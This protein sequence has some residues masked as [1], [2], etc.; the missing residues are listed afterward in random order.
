MASELLYFNGVNATRGEYAHE[1]MTADQLADLI[2][3]KN[4]DTSRIDPEQAQ[5]NELRWRDQLRRQGAFAV[6][7]GVQP[8][9]LAETGW[10]V[11]FPAGNQAA[12]REA[13]SELLEWR[14]AQAG[15]RYR[16]CIG[17]G[18]YR[19]GEGKADFLRRQGAAPSGPV[20]PDRF[21]YY[22]LIVGSPEE[23][24]FRWQ[25]QLDVQYAVGRLHFDDLQQYAS[26]ARSVVDAEKG[27][28][29]L[30]RRMVFFG[31][32]NPDDIATARSSS[33]LVL[34]LAAQMQHD[35]GNDG[36]T[37]ETIPGIEAT[38]DRLAG[39]LG[40]AAPAMLFTASHGA[41]FDKIDPRQ[42]IHQG[43]ILCSDW[44]GPRQWSGRAIPPKFYFAGEDVDPNAHLLGSM[45]FQ[46]AC[47]GGGTPRH[48]DFPHLS[49][50]QS[51]IAEQAF[52]AALPRALLGHPKGGALAVIGHVERAWTF[53]FS[54]PRNTNPQGARQIETFSSA[55]RR[56]MLRGLPVGHAIEYFNE[57]YA[58]LATILTE[59]MENIR[60][61]ASLD[62]YE[63]SNRW[64]EHN[65]ARSYVVLG[66][67]AVRLPLAASGAA[68]ERATIGEVAAPSINLPPPVTSEAAGTPMTDHTNSPPPAAPSAA[69]A[70]SQAPQAGYPQYSA[71][72][73]VVIYAGYGPPPVYPG[74]ATPPPTGYP[75]ATGA[76]GPAGASF[77]VREWFSGGQ[78]GESGMGEFAQKLSETLKEFSERLGTTLKGVL[79]DATVLEIETYVASD[80][81]AAKNDLSNAQL[82]AVTRMELDGDTKVLVPLSAGQLD[83]QLWHVHTSMVALAQ[84]NRAEMIRAIAAAAAGLFGALN[85]K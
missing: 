51:S 35:A 23:I 80:M 69:P 41:E 85:G 52:V 76:V 42:T 34:P 7:E 54:D 18:G 14:K 24:P 10:G 61:G 31:V 74:Q 40:N 1:P 32:Q 56:L 5:L 20:D 70:A 68:G 47:F 45:V 83:E 38:K 3:G 59:D 79:E 4:A 12:V 39:L 27:K 75:P 9:N 73:P 37:I 15:P 11:I 58:E 77:G 55:M 25:Y 82:R 29:G 30:S 84:A 65:D 26:Y 71:P 72:P 36:W 49:G 44:P 13:L 28:V 16:E 46:F 62:P 78:N 48:D 50:A 57:R 53:S 19:P 67:P 17:P 66:D 63:L 22:L 21:P 64:T 81:E 33:D 43:A 6:K 60:Y 8:S 2:S